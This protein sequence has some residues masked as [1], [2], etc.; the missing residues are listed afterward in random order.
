MKHLVFYDGECGL[1]DKTVRFLLK[2]DKRE[3][4]AFAPLQGEKAK[5]LLRH[6]P[7]EF[8]SEDSLVLVENF[9][10]KDRQYYVLGK[11]VLRILWNLGGL[12]KLLGWMYV[13]PS[14]LFDYLYRIV[15]RNRK[16]FFSTESCRIPSIKDRKRFLP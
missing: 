6:I 1:C 4:F 14:F 5:I 8:K 10:S 3:M 16:K 7:E 13:L 15:A 12:W 9:D 11:A 2:V